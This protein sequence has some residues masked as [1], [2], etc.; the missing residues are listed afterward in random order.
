MGL[1]R[2]T[3]DHAHCILH[4][5]FDGAGRLAVDQADERSQANM[6]SSAICW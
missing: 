1:V 2:A 3:A 5:R 6:S 4:A